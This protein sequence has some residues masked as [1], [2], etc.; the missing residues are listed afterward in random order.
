MATTN[1]EQLA[2]RHAAALANRTRHPKQVA[3]LQAGSAA[4]NN[5][6]MSMREGLRVLDP[7]EKSFETLEQSFIKARVKYAPMRARMEMAA[8]VLA[9]GG[10][11]ELAGQRAGVSRRQVKKYYQDAEFR[12]RIEE[13]RGTMFSKVRGRI[14]KELER[15]TEPGKMER[16]E[17]LDLLR[18][19]DRVMPQGTAKGGVSIAGDVNV[20]TTNYDTIVSAILTQNARAEST[21]FPIFELDGT[22]SP[23]EDT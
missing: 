20:G 2:I 10:T 5:K 4:E 18:V 16:I 14:I 23:V 7:G 8:T 1:P 22:A 3:E 15:R 17:L 9:A 19:M 21:D 6:M 12:T 11:F 13:L